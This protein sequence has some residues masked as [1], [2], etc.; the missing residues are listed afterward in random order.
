M[1]PLPPKARLI[2]QPGDAADAG[3]D[4]VSS[5][6]L[7]IGAKSNGMCEIMKGLRSGAP[8]EGEALFNASHSAAPDA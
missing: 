7:N 1:L 8:S 3:R 4:S 5:A 2:G 6:M